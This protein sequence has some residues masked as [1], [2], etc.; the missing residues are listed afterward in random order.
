MAVTPDFSS[1][2]VSSTARGEVQIGEKNLALAQK[3]DIRSATG[4]LTL[5]MRSAA[6]GLLVGVDQLRAGGGVVVVGITGVRARAALDEDLVAVLDE[7]VNAGREQ[8]DAMLLRFDFL[9]DADDHGGGIIAWVA[10]AV[11][12]GG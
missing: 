2:S 5:T 11:P 6:K 7:L 3:A 8:P 9:G 4:S 10:A 1:A 12:S